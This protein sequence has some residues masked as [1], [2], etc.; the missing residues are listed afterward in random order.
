MNQYI[1]RVPPPLIGAELL[2]NTTVFPPKV[3]VLLMEDKAPPIGASLL[4][5]YV[6]P[7]GRFPYDT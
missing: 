2:T 6:E 3:T 4:Q 1:A 5:K 7:A